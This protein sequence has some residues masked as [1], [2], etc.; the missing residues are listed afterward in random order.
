DGIIV[1]S[2][3]PGLD[4]PA[5]IS[6]I[7][8]DAALRRTPCILL[9]A[10]DE[11]QD[12]LRALDSGADAFVHKGEGVEVALARLAVALRS[13]GQAVWREG[14]RSVSGPRRVLA[15]DSDREHLDALAARLHEEGHEV[16]R[17]VT[18][19][20][21]LELLAVQPVDCVL[22]GLELPGISG[23]EVCR[24]IKASPGLGD[25]PLLAFGA[26][27]GPE[28]SLRAIN[29]GADELVSKTIGPDLLKARLRAQLRRKQ[30]QDEVR[31]E[32]EQALRQTMATAEARAVRELAETR[33]ALL[34]EV[35][36]KNEELEAFSY[37]VSHDLRAPLRAILGF[38]RILED[39]HGAALSADAK[40][41]LARV[42]AAGHRMSQLIDD[43][44]KLA[45]LGRQDMHRQTVELDAVVQEIAEELR[46]GSPERKVE[47]VV[48]GPVRASG[49]PRLLRAALEN[50]VGNAWKYTRDQPHP[51][52][53]FGATEEDGVTVY[54]LR[55]NGAGFDMAYAGR[56]FSPFQRLH[57]ADEFEGTGV[58]LA[59]VKR[60]IHRHG[61]RIWAKS[62]PGAGAT[63]SFTLGPSATATAAQ[64]APTA[65]A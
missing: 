52:V 32:R 7:R 51:K 40:D 39:E 57:R 28:V 46:G 13:A 64:N 61:G 29:A 53:E 12:E 26:V 63:F 43:L 8:L 47:L 36:A 33:A 31:G 23:E 54:F 35:N 58:G 49:D 19:E 59:T 14:T 16:V 65:N 25:V 44:L 37:S 41:L 50:L 60:I 5:V 21:A 45:R 4:G 22:V 9:T 17:A 62:S 48:S 27:D 11:R 6:R 38:S 1:D 3:M 18:G 10:S 20:E 56:L 55:D 34:A 42:L 30:L 24:R 2:M 15:I